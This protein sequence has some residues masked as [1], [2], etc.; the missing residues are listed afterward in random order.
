[1]TGYIGYTQAFS[2]EV[3]GSATAVQLPSNLR[4]SCKRVII[5]AASDN[6]GSVYIGFTSGV[7]KP[8]GSSDITS[9]FELT[10]TDP[11]LVMDIPRTDDI[12]YICTNAGDDFTIL[13]LS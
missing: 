10:K 2:G 1:M 3:A 6:A 8:D 9:G 7:T 13:I 5:R 12:F 4:R 11:P